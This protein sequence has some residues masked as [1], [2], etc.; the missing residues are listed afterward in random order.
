MLQKQIGSIVAKIKSSNIMKTRQ[1]CCNNWAEYHK[2][3]LQQF[4]KKV[5]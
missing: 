4:L 5:K 1:Q 3:K 2:N